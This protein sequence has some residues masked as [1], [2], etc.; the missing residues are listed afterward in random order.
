MRLSTSQ[1]CASDGAGS[2][3]PDLESPR[4]VV[5]TSSITSTVDSVVT[6]ATCNR[7]L[8]PLNSRAGF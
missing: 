5:E 3:A 6:I 1:F 4:G 8:V 7:R 2:A